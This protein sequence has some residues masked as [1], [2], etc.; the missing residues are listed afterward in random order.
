MS[1]L[2]LDWLV[3]AGV[4]L[5]IGLTTCDAC[6]HKHTNT[7]AHTHKNTNTA[8]QLSQT[9]SW[10]PPT[11]LI[12]VPLQICTAVHPR[13]RS[14]RANTSSACAAVLTDVREKMMLSRPLQVIKLSVRCYSDISIHANPLDRLKRCQSLIKVPS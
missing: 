2:C 7:R 10:K 5:E 11:L 9:S 12:T 8:L 14:V 4:W 6:T 3:S 1:R 13:A